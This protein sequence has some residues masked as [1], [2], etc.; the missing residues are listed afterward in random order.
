MACSRRSKNEGSS[1][2]L[3]QVLLPLVGLASF[4]L[5]A[6]PAAA[7]ASVAG[8]AAH[9]TT[10][11]ASSPHLS[12]VA[13]NSAEASCPGTE[14]YLADNSGSGY[15]L[16]NE[17]HGNADYVEATG[18][19]V[20]FTNISEG[21]F[22]IEFDA[23]GL[24][25]TWDSSTGYVQSESCSSSVATHWQDAPGNNGLENLQAIA[26]DDPSGMTASVTSCSSAGAVILA[27]GGNRCQNQWATVTG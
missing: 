27:G 20:T 23:A 13:P 8:S 19:C 2:K 18:N 5:L 16:T 12:V 1:M 26:D 7:G 15:Q 21:V 4:A 6:V 25:A 10:P 17:G 11:A 24:C 3:R 9:M 22:Q 14:H